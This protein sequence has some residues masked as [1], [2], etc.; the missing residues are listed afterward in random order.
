MRE[1][2]DCKV[3]FACDDTSTDDA[4]DA[5]C[6]VGSVIQAGDRDNDHHGVWKLDRNDD[7]FI[8]I[9]CPVYNRRPGSKLSAYEESPSEL[10]LYTVSP[11]VIWTY[12]WDDK[13][14]FIVFLR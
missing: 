12:N 2:S 10:L 1:I 14:L 5:I 8:S 9:W 4:H 7:N 6:N 11:K 13:S 3:D